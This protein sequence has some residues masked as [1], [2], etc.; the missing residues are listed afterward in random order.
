M[1][2]IVFDVG[3]WDGMSSKQYA[4][5]VPGTKIYAFEP[6]PKLVQ[7]ILINLKGYDCVVVPKAVSDYDG[8]SFFNIRNE[9]DW[10]QGSLLNFN[11]DVDK[12][13]PGSN[14]KFSEKLEV[15]VIKLSTFIEQNSIGVIDFLHIDAQGNDLKVLKGLENKIN[16][17]QS[18]VVEA[19]REGKTYY[20]NQNLKE[21]T[22][23]FLEDNNFKIEKIDN[24]DGMGNEV[25]IFFKK[26]S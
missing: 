13:W 10:G 14:L 19:A 12:I 26:M 15:G 2:R 7:E 16:I 11:D 24:N 4:D 25:N 5:E 18:G 22:V 21:E 17:V 1:S 6:V 3:A 23:K 8:K 9:G 20:T